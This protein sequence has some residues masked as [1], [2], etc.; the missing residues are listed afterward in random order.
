MPSIRVNNIDLN[1]VDRGSGETIVLIHNVVSNISALDQNISVLERNFRVIACDLRGHGQTTH[2]DV[3][4]TARDFY[5]FDNISADISELLDHLEVDRFTLV[6]QAYWG[7]ST[8]AHVYERHAKRVNGLLFSACDLIASPEGDREPYAGLGETAVRNF[9]RMIALARAEGLIA[10]FEERLKSRTFWGPTVLDSPEILACF[11]RLHEETSPIAFANFPRFHQRTLDKI[12]LKLG[13]LDTPLMLLLGVE[14]SHNS[15]MVA[16]MR[17]LYP[18][19]H[20]V[21]LPNCGHYPTIENPSD[22]N[23]AVGNF[24]TGAAHSRKMRTL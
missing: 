14:D 24:V 18:S 10:V 8:A 7:V 1:Y 22:F 20:V 16:N 21:F 11:R 3:E 12:L 15:Q 13:E 5:T 2:H 6:G 4:A 19:T 9:E 23:H 17:R